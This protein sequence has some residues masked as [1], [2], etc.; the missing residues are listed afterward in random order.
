MRD[1]KTITDTVPRHNLNW[2]TMCFLGA[3]IVAFPN[4][5]C[6][7]PEWKCLC[8]AECRVLHLCYF[9]I[10][11]SV[12]F[13]TIYYGVRL[14]ISRCA[15]GREVMGVIVRCVLPVCL[16]G[17]MLMFLSSIA[18]SRFIFTDARGS[19]LVFQFIVIAIMIPNICYLCRRN[20]SP[21]NDASAVTE[22][23]QRAS[24]HILVKVADNYVPVALKEIAYFH[25]S[26]RKTIV[27][28]LTGEI[29]EYAHSL[30]GIMAEVGNDNFFRANKQFII[31]KDAVDK[32]T[33]WFDSRLLIKLRVEDTPEPIYVSKNKASQLKKWFAQ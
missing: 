11:L 21:G 3:L 10:R 28:T 33:V 31:S 14:F 8:T 19:V 15:G 13:A 26:N 1:R 4:I 5:I 23:P 32:M 18:V 2:G 29:Y 17:Y 6:F 27:A 30:D 9:F 16:V 20:N 25:S 24:N 7:Y 12:F 22:Q